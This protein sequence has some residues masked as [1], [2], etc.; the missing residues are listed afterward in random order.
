MRFLK[1]CGLGPRMRVAEEKT[2]SKN[3]QQNKM[4]DASA[5]AAGAE[6]LRAADEKIRNHVVGLENPDDKGH[7]RE[8]LAVSEIEHADFILHQYIGWETALIVHATSEIEAL[9]AVA[10]KIVGKSEFEGDDYDEGKVPTYEALFGPIAG[11]TTIR[12]MNQSMGWCHLHEISEPKQRHIC[13][14]E[15]ATTHKASRS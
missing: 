12:I 11:M 15:R 1:D 3:I 4:S 7:M 8:F 6:A 14:R 5:A 9:V 2:S 10:D 13:V